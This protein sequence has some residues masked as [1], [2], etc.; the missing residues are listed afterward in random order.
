MAMGDGRELAAFHT[1]SLQVMK[2]GGQR[3]D[4]DFIHSSYLTGYSY[5]TVDFHQISNVHAPCILCTMLLIGEHMLSVPQT[6]CTWPCLT[7]SEALSIMPHPQSDTTF[8]TSVVEDK[9][10][11]THQA[12]PGWE[13][14]RWRAGRA[15]VF[16][17][18]SLDPG[19]CQNAAL[20]SRRSAGQLR[21]AELACCSC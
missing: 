4:P 6:N 19:R 15:H 11:E 8:Y 16:A 3:P 12:E 13:V 18:S 20:A 21:R 7:I 14:A 5:S 10:V 9:E 1:F 17:S 2:S